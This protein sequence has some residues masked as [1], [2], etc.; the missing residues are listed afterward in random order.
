MRAIDILRFS[1]E[2]LV[3]HR[4]RTALSVVG[5]AV[6]ISAVIALTALGEGARRYVVDEFAALGSNLL[7]V[8]PGKVETTGFVPI[9]GVIHDLTLDDV[10]AIQSRLHRIRQAAPISMGTET[11]RF[12]GRGRSAAI[13]GTTSDYQQ[14]RNLQLGAGHFLSPGDLDQGGSEV[15]LGIKIAQELFGTDPALGQIVR[16]GEWRFRVVGILAPTGRSMGIFDMDD[17]ALVPVKTGLSMFNRRSLFR[18]LAEVGL[19]DD[20]DT[21]R[22]D[23][24]KLLAERHRAEDVTVISQDALVASFG[25]ILQAMT[26]ALA[27][28]ASVS[29]AV[30]GVGIMNVMLVAVTERKGEIGLLKALGASNREILAAFLT[31]A[32]LLSTAGGLLGLGVGYIVVGLFVRVYPGFPATPPTWA[33]VFV[34]S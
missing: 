8:I 5:L 20:M 31:E 11:V 4:L 7:I 10:R 9:G 3:G 28:I 32:V 26:L 13:L 17:L 30:A 6:G 23:I 24:E 14:M 16:I 1:T 18:I 22:Q 33:V 21:A 25:A 12:R 2:A 15:I 29:L 27:G 19:S 34:R